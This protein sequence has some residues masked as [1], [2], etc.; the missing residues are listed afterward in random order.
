V[1][2]IPAAIACLPLAVTACAIAAT[3]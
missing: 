2:T 3:A 1:L